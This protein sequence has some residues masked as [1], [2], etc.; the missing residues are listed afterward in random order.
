VT[1]G[2]PQRPVAL[3]EAQRMSEPGA[4]RYRGARRRGTR[5]RVGYRRGVVV[6]ELDRELIVA[7]SPRVAS[8]IA[9][10]LNG[11]EFP[12]GRS[13]IRHRCR[14]TTWLVAPDQTGRSLSSASTRPCGTRRLSPSV[15]S[16]RPPT[17]RSLSRSPPSSMRSIR[18]LVPASCG[19]WGGGSNRG[20]GQCSGMSP[21]VLAL[22]PTERLEPTRR[23]FGGREG[24]AT[25]ALDLYPHFVASSFP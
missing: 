9:Q 5:G 2:T 22:L 17:G 21:E 14:R 20:L 25:L 4:K 18:D 1:S 7:R 12:E 15:Y 8:L 10:L 6:D 13:K 19:G 24:H 3:T 23:L 16:L 11:E